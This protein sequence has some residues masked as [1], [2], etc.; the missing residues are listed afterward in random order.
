[1]KY[2]INNRQT[3][4]HFIG[5][6]VGLIAL[7]VILI[8]NFT[9]RHLESDTEAWIKHTHN[10]KSNIAS[11][12]SLIQDAETG[13]R[14]FLLTGKD[15]YL[16]PFSRAINTIDAQFASLV[17]NTQYNPR[18]QKNIDR[19]RLLIDQKLTELKQTITLF[20]KGQKQDAYALVNS[21]HGQAL[22]AD[23]RQVT[24]DMTALEDGLLIEQKNKLI[25]VKR[26]SLFSTILMAAIFVL[27]VYSVRSTYRLT[28]RIKNR[29]KQLRNLLQATTNG[30][31]SFDERL[32]IQS[33]NLLAQDIF[34]YSEDEMLNKHLDLLIPKNHHTKHK[35]DAEHF[36]SDGN[37]RSMT[38]GRDVYGVNKGGEKV[39]L[40]IGLSKVT[41][42]DGSIEIV[43]TISDIT[44]RKKAENE[45]FESKKFMQLIFDNSPSIIFVKNEELKIVEA[46][47]HFLELY[48]ESKRDQVLG[49][50]FFEDYSKE[51]AKELQKYDR[52][53][54]D[55]GYSSATETFNLPN[56]SQRT[57][58]TERVRFKDS[59]NQRFILGI[60]NDITESEA[61][62]LLLQQMHNIFSDSNLC[63]SEKIEKILNVG[64]RYYQL[65]LGIVSK[66]QGDQYSIRYVSNPE[67]LQTGESFDLGKTYCAITYQKNEPFYSHD[68]TQSE[69]NGHP[70]YAS[71]E[72]DTYIGCKIIVDGIAF[73]TVNFSGSEKRDREFSHREVM[74]L[75]HIAQWI[76]F[77]ITQQHHVE[78][79]DTLIADLSDSNQ[80]LEQFAYVASHD[81][82]EPI[83][84]LKTFT[85]YLIKDVEAGKKERVE[86]DKTFIDNAC[87]RMTNLIDDILQLSRAGN[88]EYK[89]APCN[90]DSLIEDIQYSLQVRIEETN[91]KIHVE[92]NSIPLHADKTQ[93][94]L[95]L[96]NLIQNSLKFHKPNEAPDIHI[97]AYQDNDSIKLVV[98]DKGIGIPKGQ[99]DKIFGIFK[100]LHNPS[101]YSGTG[102][103]LAVVSKIMAR[104]LGAVSVDSE[105]N[106]G[107]SFTLHF[108]LHKERNL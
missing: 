82:K 94:S 38:T 30:I 25:R 53:A 27:F 75:K 28:C 7:V 35:K 47:S 74:M 46:N 43:A 20:K 79:K 12:L 54:F 16:E 6:G 90:L 5:L 1:M 3:N 107:A 57:L 42:D 2:S 48:P 81:L 39:A 59:K 91:A 60:S 71:F 86:Q 84:T 55:K 64:C 65:P 92:N 49:H 44:E 32:T 21:D 45:L 95:A 33:A 67:I 4:A 89:L 29:E 83:R 36:I 93:L 85:G 11:L 97:R 105:E 106:K 99:S 34:G 15:N 78:E 62:L 51:E 69:F 26:F 17:K 24:S 80:Q 50:Y 52:M 56:G 10:I 14:G 102:I 40:E 108:P 18:Q 77:N 13:Q 19:L 73:G 8:I 101:E 72:L 68:F 23:I 76:G 87:E 63:F 22:M 9:I 58:H 41:L 96:Q 70:C 103:G 31:I 88:A 66:I 61:E 100:K 37:N 98:S 104:H